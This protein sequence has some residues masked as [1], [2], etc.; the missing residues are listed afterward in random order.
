VKILSFADTRFPI[1]RANGVQTMATCHALA[2][3]G[4]DVTL[5][6]R[7]DSTAPARDPFAF[8]D[9]TP[10]ERLHIRTVPA[11]ASART[12]RAR[13]LLAALRLARASPDAV[14]YTR[15]LGV[16][17]LLLQ[18]PAAHRPRIVYESHGLAAT[19]SAELPSLLGRPDI[20]PSPAKLRRLDARERLVW[21]RAPAWVAITR[22]LAAELESRYGPRRHVFVV[23][24]GARPPDSSRRPGGLPPAAPVD[25]MPVAAYAGH[26]YH[27]KGADVFVRALAL[28]PHVRGL[29]V[30]GHPAEPD[31]ARIDTLVADLRLAD[32]VTVTGL[33]APGQVRRRLEDASILVLPNTATATS[34]RYSSPL[35][36]FEY[37]TLGRPIVA[38]DL[39]AIREVLTHERTALLVPP[40]DPAALAAALTRLA[41][42]PALGAALG[43]AARDLASGYTWDERARWLE[44]A[45]EA[46][47]PQ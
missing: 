34:E 6:V 29:I 17:A 3:R 25:Q 30:G 20:A 16:A 43:A 5:V 10:L 46:A 28:A 4:H 1:E 40:D 22:A 38:S 11:T 21:Q 36:L 23:P 7:P 27:W 12:R 13:F 19:V 33:V 39:P 44:A 37:L 26:L 35:K 31:R 14:V 24:D 9:L 32:R 15:D 42:D 47:Q 8:Y 41:A 45:L 18:L 2:A